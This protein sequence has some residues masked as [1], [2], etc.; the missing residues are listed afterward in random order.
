MHP[1]VERGAAELVNRDRA[2]DHASVDPLVEPHL[3]TCEEELRLEDLLVEA[4]RDDEGRRLQFRE[5]PDER[6]DQDP[7]VLALHREHLQRGHRIDDDALVPL[8]RPLE[9]MRELLFDH[10]LY[11]VHGD[12]EGADLRRLTDRSEEH[13]S[14]LQ[15][16][17]NLVCRL[18]LEKKKNNIV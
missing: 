7:A 4:F 1:V 3:A 6:L 15:S 5:E 17:S 8:L 12:L 13:T 16:Q 9:V 11:A 14:E 2:A 10:L 18:L